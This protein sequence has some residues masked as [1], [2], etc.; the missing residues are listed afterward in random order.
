MPKYTYRVIWKD[1]YQ[2][3]NGELIALNDGN[4]NYFE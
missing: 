3:V 1:N 4:I 2:S